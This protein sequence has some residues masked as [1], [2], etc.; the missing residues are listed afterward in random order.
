[1]RWQFPEMPAMFIKRHFKPAK[2]SSLYA[3]SKL[4]KPRSA[5]QQELE[6]IHYLRQIGISTLTPIACGEMPIRFWESQSFIITEEMCGIKLESYIVDMPKW[7]QDID[8][9]RNL[10]KKLAQIANTMHCHQIHHQDFYLGHILISWQDEKNFEL[11]LIDLQ[12]MRKRRK[13]G[14]RW[15][16][17]DISQLNY[18]SPPPLVTKTDRMRFL[19]HYQQ[20]KPQTLRDR[21]WISWIEMRNRKMARHQEN[22]KMRQQKQQ[23]LQ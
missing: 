12:R 1:M 16:V 21:L 22:K 14:L 18:G 9:R 6:A 11:S 17:K 15:R 13:L 10:V 5:A 23:T 19:S 2:R 3:W 4:H 20:R 7:R 8:F